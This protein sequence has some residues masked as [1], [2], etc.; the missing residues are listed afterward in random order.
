[1]C[2]C[3]NQFFIY[4]KKI[5]LKKHKIIKIN[6][7]KSPH[8]HKKAQQHFEQKT[9]KIT[10]VFLLKLS[11]ILWIKQFLKLVFHDNYFNCKFIFNNICLNFLFWFFNFTMLNYQLNSLMLK[12]KLKIKLIAM[13]N[14]LKIIN[15]LGKINTNINY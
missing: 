14:Y 3:L 13:H 12:K 2:D 11:L 1:M 5:M 8:I 10:F 9:Y 6:L 4:Q 15:L 7:L